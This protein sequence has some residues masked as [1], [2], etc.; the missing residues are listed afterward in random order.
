MNNRDQIREAHFFLR[1]AP[2]DLTI[3]LI[4]RDL[5]LAK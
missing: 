4:D 1:T 5:S 3:S 2:G